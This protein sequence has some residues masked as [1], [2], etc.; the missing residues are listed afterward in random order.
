MLIDFE[1][2]E[3]AEIIEFLESEENLK[4]RVLEAEELINSGDN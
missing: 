3:I 4:E 2:F 1:V